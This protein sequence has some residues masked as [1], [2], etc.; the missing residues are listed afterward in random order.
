TVSTAL[1]RSGSTTTPAPVL[2]W[3]SPHS[4]LA[5]LVP[6]SPSSVPPAAM[7]VTVPPLTCAARCA[8][9]AASSALCETRT[10]PTVAAVMAYPECCS[11]L[12]KGSHDPVGAAR[13]ADPRRP[14]LGH[15][16]SRCDR[17]RGPGW[18]GQAHG[19]RAAAH[20]GGPR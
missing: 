12:L 11:A 16:A 20:P 19:A 7:I 10:I 4:T 8:A 1:P 3:A 9:P 18:P 6:R 2:A 14:R 5:A 13:S 17:D 15:A